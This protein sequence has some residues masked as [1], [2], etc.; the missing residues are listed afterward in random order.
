MLHDIYCWMPLYRI[1]LK[2]HLWKHMYAGGALLRSNSQLLYSDISFRT[3]F[4]TRQWRGCP[5]FVSPLP[6]NVIRE[7]HR[8]IILLSC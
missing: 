8:G 7:F 6:H 3:S 5:R 2:L 4:T 1:D